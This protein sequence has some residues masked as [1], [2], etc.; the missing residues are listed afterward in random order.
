MWWEVAWWQRDR[1]YPHCEHCREHASAW[2]G[3]ESLA[4]DGSG[5]SVPCRACEKA[6][7]YAQGEEGCTFY[8]MARSV[9]EAADKVDQILG[10]RHYYKIGAYAHAPA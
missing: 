8:V 3:S 7:A 5:H 9:D 1:A 2:D 6:N 4:E 10:Q